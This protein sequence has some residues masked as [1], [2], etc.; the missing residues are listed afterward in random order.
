MTS[1]LFYDNCEHLLTILFLSVRL[2]FPLSFSLFLIMNSCFPLA[3][4]HPVHGNDKLIVE[5]DV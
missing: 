5:V 3:F 1:S 4:V 2:F